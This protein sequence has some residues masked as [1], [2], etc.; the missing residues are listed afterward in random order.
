MPDAIIHAVRPD[1]FGKSALEVVLSTTVI[2]GK[3]GYARWPEH[4]PQD[5]KLFS[6][7]RPESKAI[8]LNSVFHFLTQ[9]NG[10]LF[11]RGEAQRHPAARF[12][13]VDVV[14]VHGQVKDEFG[15]SKRH[16]YRLSLSRT[17]RQMH[18]VSYY[19]LSTSISC[20]TS[21]STSPSTST[22]TIT[23]ATSTSTST[24]TRPFFF[25]HRTCRA[26]IHPA[27]F[28]SNSSEGFKCG[29]STK[30]DPGCLPSIGIMRQIATSPRFV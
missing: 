12:D 18:K 1:L 28:Q 10:G 24:S 26:L 16:L 17:R 14:S 6:W 23:T 25:G 7:G 8:P 30:C 9:P 19:Y 29:G 3:M 4:D 21:S 2:R 27:R 11:G 20:S 13:T 15:S 22:S 5:G